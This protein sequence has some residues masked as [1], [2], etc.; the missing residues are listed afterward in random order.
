MVSRKTLNTLLAGAAALVIGFAVPAAY[1]MDDMNHG[2]EHEM[3]HE[4]HDG[5]MMHN[6]EHCMES[7]D[8]YGETVTKCDEAE[9][10]HDDEH[11]GEEHGEEHHDDMHD[12]AA[13]Q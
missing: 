1:A 5:D 2:E 9:M 7:V 4:A 11:H 6:E 10:M 12:D 8:E 3:H 13:H